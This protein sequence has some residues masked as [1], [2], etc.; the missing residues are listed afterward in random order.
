MSI[1]LQT[2]PKEKRARLRQLLSWGYITQQQANQM[3]RDYLRLFKRVNGDIRLFNNITVA[4]MLKL[5][6]LV[7]AALC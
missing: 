2:N 5:V 7:F 1:I 3:Y 4:N 6:G